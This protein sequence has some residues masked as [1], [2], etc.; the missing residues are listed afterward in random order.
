V[1]NAIEMIDEDLASLTKDME[2]FDEQIEALS[3][4][5]AE[6]VAEIATLRKFRSRLVAS[7]G[8][9][10]NRRSTTAEIK[11]LLALKPRTSAE[12]AAEL[13]GRLE[14]R[15]KTSPRRLI[16]VTINQ[17]LQ[18]KQIRRDEAGVNHLV[19]DV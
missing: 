19:A 4:K 7:E 6:T 12:L 10:K 17:L 16:F 18:R 13:E 15:G 8:G 1:A 5:R 9:K 2:S 14:K 11:R 3:Q